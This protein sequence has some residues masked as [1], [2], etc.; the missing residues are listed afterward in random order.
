MIPMKLAE[1]ASA[2]NGVLNNASY[3]ALE[4]ASIET[5]TRKL[6]AGG[7]F[8]PLKGETFDGHDFIA[9]ALANG[10][11]CALSEREADID[12]PIIRVASTRQ[13]LLALAAHYRRKFDIPVVAITG[14]AGKTTTKDLIASVL[15]EKFN[16]LKTHVNENNEIGLPKTVFRLND[17]AEIAVL[18]MGMNHFGE[19]RNLSR[20]AQPDIV[21][22]TNVG[23]AH[24]E[25][26]G[27]REGVLAA[28]SEAFD[29]LRP[30]GRIILNRDD[31]MLPTLQ[32][33]RDDISYYGFDSGNACYATDIVHSGLSGISF[34]CHTP[35]ETFH[36][37]V[38]LPGKH[39]VSNALAAAAVGDALGLSGAEIAKGIRKFTP[40]GMRC[41]TFT[42]AKGLTI[43]DDSYNANPAAM[44]ATLDVLQTAPGRRIAILGDMLELGAFS[45]QLHREVGAY[46]ASLGLAQ[47]I[48]I[49]QESRAM[50]EGALDAGGTAR[51]FETKADFLQ[52]IETLIADGG[53]F[54]IKASRGMGFEQITERLRNA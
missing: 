2:V 13:A 52:M 6:C 22:I 15:S 20:T 9:A 48:C 5:D 50:Y 10:T 27:S 33:T 7:L 19:M 49:G 1:I 18:E 3:V 29:F 11:V 37:H 26:L 51:H 42:T 38:P 25:N 31:D 21:V 8:V 30:G 24:I 45:A 40:S 23:T 53:T 47:I 12:A 36:V 44:K 4:A 14:S 39:M 17:I 32:S 34:V 41:D 35:R 46:A 43:I 16:V 54:L 28:K